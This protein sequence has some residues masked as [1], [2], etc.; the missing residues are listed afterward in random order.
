MPGKIKQRK[1]ITD[2]LVKSLTN[3]TMEEWFSVLDH[4]GAQKLKHPD[5][6]KVV[7]SI[8]DLQPLGEWNQNLLVTS[9]EWSR[10]IKE[11]GQKKN[12]FEVS[13]SK[14]IE[15][16][17]NKLFAAWINTAKRLAWL[18]DDIIIRKSTKDKSARITWVPDNTSLSV[19]FYPKSG[20][21]S[22][23]V[24]QHQ[25]ILSSKKAIDMKE[26]WSEAL[27]RLKGLL[28]AE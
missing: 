17:V 1:I 12:G 7:E 27:D 6:F 23:V 9:Y 21:K 3:K 5:I 10:G 15:V 28:S 26:F 4:K 16:P 14:T 20:N 22:Q 24:V 25:K 19:D 11:R 2:K 18:K 13:I 8:A